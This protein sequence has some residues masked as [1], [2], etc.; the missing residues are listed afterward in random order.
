MTA[1]RKLLR[2]RS[3]P[4]KF[5]PGRASAAGFTLIE[6]LVVIA[7]I[8]I[9]AAM[10]LPALHRGKLAAQNTYCK[11]NLRQQ[12]VALHMY[13][14]DTHAYPFTVNGSLSQVWYTTLGRYYGDNDNIMKCP[15]FKGHIP[16]DQAV[17][18]LFGN[19]YYRRGPGLIAGVSYGYN[20]FGIGSA[21]STSWIVYLGLGPVAVGGVGE[22]VVR[23]RDVK[24]PSDM[25]AI[26]DSMPQPGFPDIYAFLLSISSA[27]N[28]ERHNH[29]SNVL[30]A[31]G[32]V[33]TVQDKLLI[34]TEDFNR[35]RWNRDNEP[36]PEVPNW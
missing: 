14:S 4:E 23:E 24:S 20:G 12:G 35:R 26:A 11:N 27:P 33:V 10:L 3:G 29:G 32:H 5:P 30:F 19:A 34:S 13:K 9:L 21:N 36:H 25:I 6:L 17:V 31:D 28:P 15:T 7:I 22:A 2:A 18:F 8:A 16:F 1:A